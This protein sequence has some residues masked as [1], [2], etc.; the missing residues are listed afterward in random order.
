MRV[1]LAQQAKEILG[2]SDLVIITERVDDVA[3][4]IGQ[5][6]KMGLPE[7]LDR[8][9]PRHW[10]QRGLSWGWTAVI[11][12]AYIVTEG[13]HRKV[14]ME[15]YLKGMHHTLSRLTAQVVDP[16][17]FSDDRLSHLLQ[18]LSKPA[19]WHKIERDLNERSIEIY[20]L[21]QDMIRCDATT[22]SG[23]HEV[24]EE[25]LVQFGHSK[26]D[27]TRPQIKVMMGALDP[28]GMPL[29]TDV[30]SGERADDG[31]YLPI[32]ERIRTGLQT[33]G[34]LFVGDC[35]MSA[36]D[37]R[38]YLARHQDLYLSP[39]PLTGAT[40]EAMD[41]WITEGVRQGERG[42]LARIMRT[43]DR[44]HTVL[45]AEGY[46]LERTCEAPDEAGDVA[47]WPERV[48]VVRSPMHADQQA[49]GLEKRLSHAETKLAALTPPRG[50]GKRQITDE[51]TLVAA[52]AR[53][54]TEHRVDGLLS[55]TWEK[56]VEQTTQYVGRGR[57]SVH[58]EKR[59][60]QK[61]R[62]HITHIARQA[63][64]IAALRQRLGWKAFVTNAASQRL[65]LQEAVL[66]YRH[67]YRVERIF[68]R[69]KSRVHIA[70]LFVKLNDQIEGLTYLL[71]LGVRVL[72]V[73]EFVLRRS[74]QTDQTT[75]PG[76]HPENKT[77]VTDKPTAERILKAFAD[78]SLTIIKN[79]AGEEI[80]RRL[81]SLSGLQKDILQRLGLGASLYGQLE[82]Q[83]MGN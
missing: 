61:T 78:V 77:R 13:D 62:Y 33:P 58:R 7:V 21:S 76:L 5:M 50:R 81:T 65:S 35:K 72:T 18:H 59:V 14:S 56:Q 20:D 48:L 44:G 37:T 67:E 11:W 2:Q 60:I 34:L 28:L 24:T 47:A 36:L 15:T 79:A 1:Q 69:L 63:D 71:T 4:L 38:A 41:A 49:A 23:G 26:D 70:P 46:E 31:L 27:P 3:L 66:C 45:A 8:H 19:Y 42:T 29:A 17:D 10:T 51:A 73:L 32:M 16:L 9:I 57:G 83:E 55:V 52:I 82:I 39:L 6:V 40:A 25:G 75:L 22:V 43:N 74:L 54:L 68:N 64:T 12:L 53:V 80:L 30:L